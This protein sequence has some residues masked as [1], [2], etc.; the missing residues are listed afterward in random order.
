MI[1]RFVVGSRV[2]Y[3]RKFLKKA[4]YNTSSPEWWAQGTITELRGF[5]TTSKGKP[6]SIANITWDGSYSPVLVV[7]TN[8]LELI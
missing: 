7:T 2:R 5:K 1:K 4:G 6:Y 8:N 3:C